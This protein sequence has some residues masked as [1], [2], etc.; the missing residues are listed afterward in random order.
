M[1]KLPMNAFHPR[2]HEF[3]YV[4]EAARYCNLFEDPERAMLELVVHNLNLGETEVAADLLGSWASMDPGPEGELRVEISRH[5]R[6][7][8][9]PKKYE[10]QIAR[11]TQ[12]LV[13]ILA[14]SPEEAKELAYEVADEVV[15]DG[16]L[17]WPACRE[18]VRVSEHNN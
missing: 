15:V 4:G 18:V 2:G 13:R 10:V 12:H 5:A 17:D 16:D 7:V 6:P 3:E 11:T 1:T 9:A 8:F 14:A